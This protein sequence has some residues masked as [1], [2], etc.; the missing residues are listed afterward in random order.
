MAQ[1]FIARDEGYGIRILMS[2]YLDRVGDERL[3]DV[4]VMG[5]NETIKQAVIAGL[6]IALISRHTV[7]KELCSGRLVE[8]A[9]DGM[10]IERQ[11]FLLRR[12]DTELTPSAARIR[13]VITGLGGAFLPQAS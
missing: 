13:T 1:T 7:V 10:P 6:G 8:L 4:M 5:S 11:W 2:C 3:Y 9:A 12:Q